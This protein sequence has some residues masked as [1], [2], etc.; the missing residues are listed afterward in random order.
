MFRRKKKVNE[1]CGKSAYFWGHFV[2]H[3]FAHMRDLWDLW[4]IGVV[5]RPSLQMPNLTRMHA[6]DIGASSNIIN[7]LICLFLTSGLQKISIWLM[8]PF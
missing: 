5:R 6:K 4:D 7:K 1:C 2:G 3:E 8:L